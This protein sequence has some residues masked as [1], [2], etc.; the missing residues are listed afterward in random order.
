MRV[1]D[2]RTRI[3]LAL[4]LLLVGFAAY[5]L[6]VYWDGYHLRDAERALER[7]DFREAS[8]HLE[9]YLTVRPNDLNARLLAAQAAFPP[10]SFL[11]ASA[12]WAI[13]WSLRRY[14]LAARIWAAVGPW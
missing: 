3:A 11:M 13:S 5:R 2:K 1:G 12:S 14:S 6:Y 10:Y 9:E 7:R 8:R 4:V